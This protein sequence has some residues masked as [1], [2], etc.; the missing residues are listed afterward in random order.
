MEAR[1]A[2]GRGR[3]RLRGRGQGHERRRPPRPDARLRARHRHPHADVLHLRDVPPP[4]RQARQDRQARRRHGLVPPRVAAVAAPHRL[5]RRRQDLSGRGAAGD[6]PR[7]VP[8]G[9]SRVRRAV[10]ADRAEVAGERQ[11]DAALHPAQRAGQRPQPDRGPLAPRRP[12]APRADAGPARTRRGERPCRGRR[13]L[14]RLLPQHHRLPDPD[15]AGDG[16]RRRRAGRGAQA[17]PGVL[18]RQGPG[19]HPARGRLEGR[20]SHPVFPGRPRRA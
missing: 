17:S 16:H 11:P 4:R 14:G 10:R 18:R 12:M 13:R 7:G 20:D 3:R 15:D 9:R 8:Q 2:A 6:R 19:G 5:D 1:D